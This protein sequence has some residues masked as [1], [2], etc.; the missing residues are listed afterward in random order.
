MNAGRTDNPRFASISVLRTACDPNAPAYDPNNLDPVCDPNSPTF[1][2]FTRSRPSSRRGEI[3]GSLRLTGGLKG[4]W[5]RTQFDL[6]YSPVASVYFERSELNDISHNLSANWRHNYTP[7]T[8]LSLSEYLNYTPEQD[9]DPNT[10]QQNA[11]LV[12]RTNTTNSTFRG[13]LGFQVSRPT[14]LS[15][16]YRHVLRSFSSDDFV[17]SSNHN[18]G[19]Q[20]QRRLAGRSSI[21]AGYEY[22]AFS[23]SGGGNGAESHQASVGYGFASPRGFNLSANVGYNILRPEDPNSEDSSGLY[24]NGS[25]GWQSDR[26]ATTVGYSRGFRDGGGAFATAETH[27]AYG[28]VRFNLTQG[29]SADMIVARNVHE[30]LATSSTS[31]STTSS[32]SSSSDETIRSLN[33]TLSLNYTFAQ[34]WGLRAAYT[35]YRQTFDGA[36]ATALPEIRSNRYM[37][38]INWSFQ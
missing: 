13:T 35:H 7:R 33:G 12:P 10:L 26:V 16:S 18:L 34:N 4:R 15:W 1:D 8:A 32:A 28:N 31:S 9:P 19:M 30:R 5:D 6:A 17:D 20:W 25:T 22:G 21:S 36:T 3:T 14:S 23:F 38:G 27:N 24:L 2:P 29:L 11:L 37:V